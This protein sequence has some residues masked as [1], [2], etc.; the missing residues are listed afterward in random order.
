M[1]R[2]KL[3]TNEDGIM[4]KEKGLAYCGLKTNT[5]EGLKWSVEWVKE[6]LIQSITKST[7]DAI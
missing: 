5:V 1:N 7:G 3:Y 6:N 4:N 2:G